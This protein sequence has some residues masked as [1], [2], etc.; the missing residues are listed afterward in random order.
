V[1]RGLIVFDAF[2]SDAIPVHLVTREAVELYFQK[3]REDGVLAFNVTNRYVDLS[4]VLGAIARDLGVHVRGQG[5]RVSPEEEWEGK[6]SSVWII[7]SRRAEHLGPLR[8]DQRWGVPVFGPGQRAW[9]DDY[10]N[11]IGAMR[12][13]G[14]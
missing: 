9:T 5:Y 7:M 3:I 14:G 6:Q 4:P 1:V 8:H 12:F 11:L 10:S 13:G 2:T